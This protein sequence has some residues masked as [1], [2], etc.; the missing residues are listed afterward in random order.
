MIEPSILRSM[1]FV[2]EKLDA[3]IICLL[4]VKSASQMADVLTKDCLKRYFLHSVA[5][6]VYM[7]Y[8]PILRRSVG[9]CCKH[10]WN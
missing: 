9:V 1:S 4:Y 10:K 6:W 3:A 7:M 5:R 8:L 2:K